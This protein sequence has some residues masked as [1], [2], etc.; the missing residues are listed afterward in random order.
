MC[1]YASMYVV[2]KNVVKV[3]RRR[4]REQE[5]ARPKKQYCNATCEAMNII[6]CVVKD[7]LNN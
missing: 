2:S 3:G 5:H 4:G 1:V 7:E 6:H